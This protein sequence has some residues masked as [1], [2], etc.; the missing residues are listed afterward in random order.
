[1]ADRE[2]LLGGFVAH[3]SEAGAIEDCYAVMRFNGKRMLSG[4]FVGNS[5]GAISTSY[6]ANKNKGISGGFCGKKSAL[7]KGCFFISA[8]EDTTLWDEKRRLKPSDL[9]SSE[10]PGKIGFDIEKVWEYTGKSAPIQFQEK[11]WT[12]CDATAKK[13]DASAQ[14]ILRIRDAKSLISFAEMVN[15]GELKAITAKVVL[16]RDI[17]LKGK[18]WTPIG[19]ERKN[20]FAGVFDGQGHSIYNFTI[21][22]Q[23]TKRK[24]FFGY[25]KGAVYNLSIDCIVKGDGDIGALVAV[26]EGK[27]GGCGA[28]VEIF[29]KNK[30]GEL[31]VGGFVAENNGSIF[32]SYVAGRVRFINI[33]FTWL[34]IILCTILILFATFKA[35]VPAFLR[36][37]IYKMIDL[38]PNLSKVDEDDDDTHNSK[39]HF[40]F[41]ISA[42]ADVSLSEGVIYT[43]FINPSS[44]N[45]NLIVKICIA[46]TIAKEALGGTGRSEEEQAELE[47]SE[48]YDPDKSMVTIAES[49]TVAPGYMLERIELNDFAKKNLREGRYSAYLFMVPYSLDENAKGAL[50]AST[51]L[52][53]NVH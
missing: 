45:Q 51:P 4:G 16:D 5:I 11:A 50:D 40:S 17:N 36:Q 13:R 31:N 33:P 28:L 52:V 38:D 3:N 43:D 14:K 15:K 27:V 19:L 29:A 20:A 49:L 22:G 44:S 30:D 18:A 12:L 42:T 8:E 48:N 53:I 9:K 24:G 6:C 41:T 39:N 2:G 34:F 46:D 32:R 35:G 21:K 26:N 37:P 47:A 23:D 25:L 10:I 7:G 1:M